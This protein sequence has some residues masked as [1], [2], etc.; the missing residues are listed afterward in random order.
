MIFGG[1]KANDSDYLIN[2]FL[3]VLLKILPVNI[4]ELTFPLLLIYIFAYC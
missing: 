2:R 3:R 4:P 1:W